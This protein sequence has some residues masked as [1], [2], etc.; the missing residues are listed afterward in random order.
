[1]GEF[2]KI[3]IFA[4]VSGALVII[5]KQT[6]PEMSALLGVVI[7]VILLLAIVNK[8]EV[9]ILFIDK[10]SKISNIDDSIIRTLLKTVL[11]AYLSDFTINVCND[12][13]A[14]SIGSKVSVIS[15]ILILIECL[16]LIEGLFQVVLEL[17]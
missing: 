16:P 9:I 5:L 10:I 7:G 4:I 14:S 6:K 11:I 17:I 13:G 8:L 15:K 3:I 2:Y 12:M 1:M